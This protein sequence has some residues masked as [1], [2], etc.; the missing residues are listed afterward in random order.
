MRNRKDVRYC[1]NSEA[2]SSSSN[3]NNNDHV[4]F[5]RFLRGQTEPHRQIYNRQNRA[6]EV[7]Y[8][9]H[10]R[11]RVWKRC[12]AR[13]PSNLAHRHYLDRVLALPDPKG[14]KFDLIG[15]R[16]CTGLQL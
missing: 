10:I 11:W 13:P 7:D 16:W 8:T 5:A 15:L 12:C 4:T 6:A 9:P 14:Q 1:I 2:Y 3:I